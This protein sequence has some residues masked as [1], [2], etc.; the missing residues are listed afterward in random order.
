M[1]DFSTRDRIRASIS[2]LFCC[3]PTCRLVSSPSVES[4]NN[5]NIDD[6]PRAWYAQSRP[7]NTGGEADLHGNWED[8]EVR[9]SRREAD[10]LSL[11]ESVAED[12]PTRRRRWRGRGGDISGSGSV[13]G[14]SSLEMQQARGMLNL[15]ARMKG[16][17][18]SRWTLLRSWW[19]GGKGAVRLPDS[20]DE[21]EIAYLEHG[22]DDEEGQRTFDEAI[23]SVGAGES[24]AR[25][26]SV[27]HFA[28][29][30]L[31]VPPAPLDESQ[32]EDRE[33]RRAKR[34]ARRRAREL[35]LSIQEFDEGAAAEPGELPDTPLLEVPAGGRRR[36]NTWTQT[37]SSSG[38]TEPDFVLVDTGAKQATNGSHGFL[39]AETAS[40]VD[41]QQ[42]MDGGDEMFGREKKERRSRR[43]AAE[44]GTSSQ[45]GDGTRRGGSSTSG[46]GNSRSHSS[47]SHT[48][49]AQT[50]TS[51]KASQVPLPG[52]PSDESYRDSSS[53]SQS[54]PRH[55]SHPSMSSNSNSTSSYGRRRT[56]THH[57]PT[58]LSDQF[59]APESQQY[60]Q[61]ENGQIQPY[62]SPGQF[63]VD[64]TG[65]EYFVPV[66]A[67]PRNQYYPSPLDFSSPHSDV[68]QQQQN[69]DHIGTLPSSLSTSYNLLPSNP[70]FK[71]ADEETEELEELA[72]SPIAPNP[73]ASPPALSSSRSD[74]I[75]F[76]QALKRTKNTSPLLPTVPVA[77]V[78]TVQDQSDEGGILDQWE[79]LGRGKERTS[80]WEGAGEGFE[81]RRWGKE[82]VSEEEESEDDSL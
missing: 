18:L 75:E 2:P 25:P 59:E 31:Q 69:Y 4:L 74:P 47:R 72:D 17:G 16:S 14:T 76:L 63:Y 23:I 7:S 55:R 27:S 49:T 48:S 10:L 73:I 44:E 33:E 68:A 45:S 53:Q 64:E 30:A 82:S 40:P 61:D 32:P 81:K 22:T 57:H 3:L 39:W 21:E 50:S 13:A 54:R 46:S 28:P 79:G 56:R 34:R 52:S 42:A 80:A 67:D 66:V 38:S 15:C 8:A 70:T 77:A 20:D 11:H 62:P 6:A 9:A 1:D 19:S 78:K 71:I 51:L 12:G 37:S 43:R 5:N 26:L 35:G 24:D 29:P 60:Y 65:Q 36:N 58:Q 41:E